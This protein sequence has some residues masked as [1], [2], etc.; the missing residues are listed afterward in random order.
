MLSDNLMFSD[1]VMLSDN[2]LTFDN[3]FHTIKKCY[4][5]AP[6]RDNNFSFF[7]L[8]FSVIGHFPHEPVKLEL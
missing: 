4:Q 3:S 7:H 5:Q 1:N 2:L 8:N 6:I